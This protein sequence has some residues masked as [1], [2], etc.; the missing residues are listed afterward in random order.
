[1]S[2][3]RTQPKAQVRLEKRI[4]AWHESK[5]YLSDKARK[6]FGKEPGSYKK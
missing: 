1:M 6:Q 4:K 5:R 2:K 3:L